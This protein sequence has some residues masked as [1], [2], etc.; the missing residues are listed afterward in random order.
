[1]GKTAVINELF[2]RKA[3]VNK[4]GLLIW[5]AAVSNKTVVASI[6]AIVTKQ[7]LLF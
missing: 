4:K 6:K 3:A 2:I 7:S 5:K 1:M